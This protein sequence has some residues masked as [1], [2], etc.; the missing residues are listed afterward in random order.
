MHHHNEMVMGIDLINDGNVVGG[1]AI[2]QSHGQ[3]PVA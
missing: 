3:V 2:I 1:G